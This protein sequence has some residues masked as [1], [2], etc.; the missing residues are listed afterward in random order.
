MGKS[1]R[2]ILIEQGSIK[3]N[4]KGTPPVDNIPDTKTGVIDEAPVEE[5]K[6]A[7]AAAINAEVSA[8]KSEKKTEKKEVK[9]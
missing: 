2:D 4:G 8:T 6:K 7:D 3:D 5:V 9:K 1:R